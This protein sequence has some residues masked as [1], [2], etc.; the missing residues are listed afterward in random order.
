MNQKSLNWGIAITGIWLAV[1]IIVWFFAGLKS[2]SSLN[3]LGD[4]LAGIFAPIAFFWLI[5]GYVQQGKQLDQNTKALEQQEKALQLQIDEMKESVK[6]QEELARIQREQFEC[7]RKILKPFVSII[8]TECKLVEYYED[9]YDQ[10]LRQY[11]DFDIVL[12]VKNSDIR[13]FYITNSNNIVLYDEEFIPKDIPVT[14][15]LGLNI[16]SGSVINNHIKYEINIIYNDSF[17]SKKSDSYVL[18]VELDKDVG[19]EYFKSVYCNK[20]IKYVATKRKAHLR[21]L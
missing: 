12:L 10:V 17:E 7:N 16:E 21:E 2:P 11:L 19:L 20:I 8:E 15:R 5:L 13:H 3:E 6:Q 4:A 14:L 18:G 1:I 9:E